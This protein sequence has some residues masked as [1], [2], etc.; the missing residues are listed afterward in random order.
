ML[1]SWNLCCVSWTKLLKIKRNHGTFRPPRI[2]AIHLISKCVRMRPKD[3]CTGP[4]AFTEDERFDAT[5]GQEERA[6]LGTWG[7][8]KE[9]VKVHCHFRYFESALRFLVEV[10]QRESHQ[11]HCPSQS[12]VTEGSDGQHAPN[13]GGLAVFLSS[14]AAVARPRGSCLGRSLC[15]GRMRFVLRC[16]KGQRVAFYW[17]VLSICSGFQSVWANYKCI[18]HR[19][20][21]KTYIQK[22][23]SKSRASFCCPDRTSPLWWLC[24]AN[25]QIWVILV[26]K[27]NSSSCT[28]ISQW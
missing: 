28:G 13:G 27:L 8:L 4:W 24:V 6:K 5:L 11:P 23:E 18:E 20:M 16:P 12:Q 14:R 15:W 9:S 17:C 22:V 1:I 19:T 7:F 2:T 3:R 25:P 26:L 10:R 21:R